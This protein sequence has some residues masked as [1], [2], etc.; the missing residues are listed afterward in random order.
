[1]LVMTLVLQLTAAVDWGVLLQQIGPA[2]IVVLVAADFIYNQ[3]RVSRMRVN[4][5]KAAEDRLNESNRKVIEIMDARLAERD[6]RIS[7]L[8]EENRL[9]HEE[10]RSLRDNLA[11]ANGKVATL[12]DRIDWTNTQLVEARTQA[13]LVPGLG[14][15]V[16][17]LTRQLDKLNNDLIIERD[18]REKAE[19]DRE[20]LQIWYD[21]LEDD[22]QSLI[23]KNNSLG[24]RLDDQSIRISKQAERMTWLE[25]DRQRL[26]EEYNRVMGKVREDDL[27]TETAQA[28]DDQP[29]N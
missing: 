29:D 22:N 17:S 15:Q 14:D 27:P 8:Q 12:S 2:G 23:R 10:N 28:G 25:A 18:M 24:E 5:E 26:E 3:V 6:K 1:M 4:M 13:A 21:R 19:G 16:G 20:K 11:T 9:Q 7:E